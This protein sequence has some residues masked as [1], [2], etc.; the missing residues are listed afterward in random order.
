MKNIIKNIKAWI[1]YRLGGLPGNEV[2]DL[3]LLARSAAVEAHIECLKP[4]IKA[5]QEI[6]RRSENSYYD[7]CCEHCGADCD[8]RD[9]WCG[10][11]Y[12]VR[13]KLEEKEK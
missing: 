2:R 5:V 10:R 12:P 11:F 9:G 4:W 1:I 6:C 13:S 8:K 7:W 3:Q